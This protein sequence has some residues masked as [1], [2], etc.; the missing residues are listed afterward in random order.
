[1]HMLA[2]STTSDLVQIGIPVAEK[3]I[4]TAG[5][6]FGLVV[7]LRLGG[8]RDLAQLNSFGLVVLLLLSNDV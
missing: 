2:A 3:A 8:K 7:L 6:Y 4:R 1:M 5:V